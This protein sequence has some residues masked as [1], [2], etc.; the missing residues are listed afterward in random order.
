MVKWGSSKRSEFLQPK[1]LSVTS[2]RA[3]KCFALRRWSFDQFR[4][5]HC[6]V[7]SFPLS[8]GEIVS[9][10][11]RFAN[12]KSRYDV[13]AAVG[14]IKSLPSNRWWRSPLSSRW[15][16]DEN[17]V[18]MLRDWRKALSIGRDSI[19]ARDSGRLFDW[20]AREMDYRPPQAATDISCPL[21]RET[22]GWHS[23]E[24]QEQDTMWQYVR[25]T[26]WGFQETGK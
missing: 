13:V 23:N 7:K 14:R 20:S 26:D 4:C 1:V 12:W 10:F 15:P 17:F 22:D 2:S 9:K 21:R 25:W 18:V 5:I 8:I 24:N 16:L 19:N 11:E 3:A 6:R